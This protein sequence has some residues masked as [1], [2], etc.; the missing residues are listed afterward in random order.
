MELK[1]YGMMWSERWGPQNLLRTES[2][3]VKLG[4]VVQKLHDPE[5]VKMNNFDELRPL[6]A[7][8]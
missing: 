2:G 6:G 4:F 1:H 7:L 8:V 5:I 3:K